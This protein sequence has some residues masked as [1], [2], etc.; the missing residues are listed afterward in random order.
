MQRE[1]RTSALV[2]ALILLTALSALSCEKSSDQ[3]KPSELAPRVESNATPTPQTPQFMQPV[4]S[5]S[6]TPLP[7]PP[8]QLDEVRSAMARV[9][10][11][12][13]E[14][15]TTNAPAFV[16]GDFN[17]DGSTDLAVITKASA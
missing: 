11:K 3:E 17:G 14:P 16:A 2:S 7:A 4:A 1:R 15:D 12:V 5:P 13:A 6:A 10:A 8:P 9:F